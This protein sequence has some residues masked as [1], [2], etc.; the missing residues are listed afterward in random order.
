MNESNFRWRWFF[1]Q[2]MGFIR[3]GLHWLKCETMYLFLCCCSVPVKLQFFF[4]KLFNMISR[5]L[6]RFFFYINIIHCVNFKRWI[7]LLSLQSNKIGLGI[8]KHR[9][10]SRYM[11]LHCGHWWELTFCWDVKVSGFVDNVAFW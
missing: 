9:N 6:L 5:K 10:Q 1:L 4:E 7:G 8:L 3:N 11:V 2:S